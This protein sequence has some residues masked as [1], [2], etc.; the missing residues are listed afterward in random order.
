MF[1]MNVN[2]DNIVLIKLLVVKKWNEDFCLQIFPIAPMGNNK[3][4]LDM[5]ERLEMQE[6]NTIS[7]L[8]L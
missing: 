3:V 4:N 6:K 2:S 8:L 5:F 7:N 1:V